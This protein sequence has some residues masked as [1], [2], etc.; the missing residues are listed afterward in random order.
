FQQPA[1]E[2]HLTSRLTLLQFGPVRLD[3]LPSLSV[4]LGIESTDSMIGNQLFDAPSRMA[5]WVPSHFSSSYF[6]RC[7]QRPRHLL[8]SSLPSSLKASER[9]RLLSHFTHST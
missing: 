5:R 4:V 3:Q 8:S 7:G 6:R 2:F 1:L 9:R